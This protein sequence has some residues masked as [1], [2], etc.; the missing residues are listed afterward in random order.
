VGVGLREP[1]DHPGQERQSQEEQE[2]PDPGVSDS[3]FKSP[4]QRSAFKEK[5]RKKV[6][7]LLFTKGKQAG[8]L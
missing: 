1:A 8:G 2:I 5:S 6:F 4:D 7:R 3:G